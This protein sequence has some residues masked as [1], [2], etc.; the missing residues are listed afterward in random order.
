[1]KKSLHH[2]QALSQRVYSCSE[3]LDFGMIVT[4]CCTMSGRDPTEKAKFN[5]IHNISRPQTHNVQGV[6]DSG[7]VN[8]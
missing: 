5:K 8:Y 2:A 7:R 4:T 6:D 1:M 3:Y